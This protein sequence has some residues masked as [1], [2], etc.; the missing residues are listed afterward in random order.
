MAKRK[1]GIA[2]V[3]VGGAVGTTMFAGIELLRKGAV[4]TH[5][6]PLAGTADAALTPYDQVEVAGWDLYETDLAKAAEEHDVLTL[7]QFSAVETELKEAR[8]WAGIGNPNFVN[9]ILGQN[10]IAASGH[11]AA[12]ERIKQDLE[13]FRERC[14]SAVV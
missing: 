12:V 2:V 11:R 8:P 3:G 7:K 5:G 13:K 1:L 4:D 6:L 14:E 10:L 9:N